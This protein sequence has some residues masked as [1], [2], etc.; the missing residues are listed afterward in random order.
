VFGALR[1]RAVDERKPGRRFADIQSGDNAYELVAA[2]ADDQVVG[3]KFH[4]DRVGDLDEQ[5]VTTSVAPRIVY[6]LE[7]VNVHEGKCE[8]LFCTSRPGDLTVEL[9]EPCAAKVRTGQVVHSRM[10][11]V[12]GRRVAV[13]ERGAAIKACLGAFACP[14]STVRE[15]VATIESGLQARAGSCLTILRRSLPI[16]G[17]VAPRERWVV[18]RSRGVGSGGELLE[19]LGGVVPLFGISIAPISGL[20][21][22]LTNRIALL[23][24]EVALFSCAVSLIAGEVSSNRNVIPLAASPIPRFSRGLGVLRFFG[25]ARI[26]RVNHD[27][28]SHARVAR[29]LGAAA[30]HLS[31]GGT[32]EVSA[33]RSLVHPYPAAAQLIPGGASSWPTSESPMI[34]ASD[35][36]PNA[37]LPGV[38]P[39]P[40]LGADDG[41][42]TR[43]PHLGK[44]MLYR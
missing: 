35:K 24:G 6:G 22:H 11:A 41:I 31:N 23:T 10:L 43:D 3:P 8:W 38:L 25:S 1:K 13:G 34:A 26:I 17:G 32:R 39:Q 30:A 21:S 36:H 44:V 42:R 2:V 27:A 7:A 9:H 33:V 28:A 12:S 40:L 20:V 18:D 5:T 37:T 4:A 29:T 15:R 16:I 19:P 14:R